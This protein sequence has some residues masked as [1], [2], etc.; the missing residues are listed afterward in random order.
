MPQIIDG[1]EHSIV[2]ET[3]CVEL[4]Q[5]YDN[6]N[7][8]TIKKNF[9]KHKNQALAVIRKISRFDA[10]GNAKPSKKK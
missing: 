7:K 2:L 6:T 4:V 1:K 5:L 10:K 3:V 9:T 8:V